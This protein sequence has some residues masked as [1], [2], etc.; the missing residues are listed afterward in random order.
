MGVPLRRRPLERPVRK[1]LSSGFGLRSFMD[2][3]DHDEAM[4]KNEAVD[5]LVKAARYLSFDFAMEGDGMVVVAG[6][7][8]GGVTDGNLYEMRDESVKISFS[9][10]VSYAG[11][12]E[13]TAEF[14]KKLAEDIAFWQSVPE[15][16]FVESLNPDN[17]RFPLEC[18]R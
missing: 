16:G 6:V 4:A 7:T 1:G 3:K 5:R 18:A 13:L 9:G 2:P 8:L 12:N 15:T 11:P 17:I 10:K 14:Q